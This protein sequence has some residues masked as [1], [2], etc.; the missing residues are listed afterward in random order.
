[1][2]KNSR[3]FSLRDRTSEAHEA[4]DALVGEFDSDA[5][6]QRYLSG[7]AAFR[8]AVEPA[9]TRMTLPENSGY[10]PSLLSPE[11][12]ADLADL[13]LTVPS[14][15]DFRH[16]DFSTDAAL[17]ALYVLEGSA[18]GAQLLVKRAAAL[19]YDASHG[20]RHLA[21]QTQSLDAWRGFLQVLDEAEP[22]DLD[23]CTSAACATFDAA[24][25][26]FGEKAYA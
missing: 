13:G 24:R 19:G 21:R 18:L 1:M 14:P 5:S 2:Q 7:T 11:I 15:V 9:L 8:L 6:Y 20:A 26:A 10:H 4:L 25:A 17:G 12:H 22:F 16:G 23:A 3:R